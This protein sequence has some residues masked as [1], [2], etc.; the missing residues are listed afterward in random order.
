MTTTIALVGKGGV[1]KTTAAALLIKLFSRKGAVLAIDADPSANLNMALGLPLTDTV[2]DVREG[3]AAAVRQG[4]FDPGLAKQDYLELKIAEALVESEGID[5]LAMGRPEGP[6]CYC[7]ANSMLRACIDRLGKSYDYVVIDCE[8]GMEH[9]SRQTTRDIDILLILSDPTI[10]GVTAAARMKGL[11]KELRTHVGRV[12]LV[13]NRANAPLSP[14][15]A[16][17]IEEAGLDLLASIPDDAHVAEL[18]ATGAPVTEL[19]ETS[20]LKRGIVEI[21]QRLGL[22]EVETRVG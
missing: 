7:A 14:Q 1:G 12:G 19:P 5:L 21:A 13:L 8:A 3:M 15:V 6:G 17:L 20:P 16:K 18:E 22:V 4:R 10:R 2:G 9:I 11:I